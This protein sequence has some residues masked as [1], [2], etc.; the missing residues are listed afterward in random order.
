M[1]GW[2]RKYTF[3]AERSRTDARKPMQLARAALAV[4]RQ[5]TLPDQG[6]SFQLTGQ[7][8]SGRVEAGAGGEL[9]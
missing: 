7:N 2:G 9:S 4:N 5:P 3:V 1:P 6:M 8:R